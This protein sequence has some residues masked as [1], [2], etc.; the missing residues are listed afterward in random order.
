MKKIFGKI[1]LSAVIAVS[2][3]AA[4]SAEKSTNDYTIAG[5]VFQNDLFM[6][7]I[8]IGMQK[9]ADEKG[10]KLLLSNSDNKVDK[11]SQLIDTYISRKV[12]AIAITPLSEKGSVAALQRAK[13][14]GIKIIIFNT[15]LEADIYESY[16][17][18]DQKELGQRSGEAARAYIEKNYPGQDVDV[19]TLS[20]RSF[21]PE[22]AEARTGGFTGEIKD[23]PNVKFVSEQDAWLAEKAIVI[24]GDII[25][26]N[27]NI[28]VLHAAN[29]GGTIGAVQAVKNAGKAGEIVVFGTDG[30]DQIAQML[31]FKDNILQVSTAQQPYEIGFKAIDV[32]VDA[33]NGDAVEKTIIVPARV[34]DRENPDDV[35]AFRKELKSF[36]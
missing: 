16:I 33:L 24:A 8:Q 6:R 22:I 28:K 32:A 25:T 20:F 26:A 27:P 2:S 9:A 14:A 19:A 34:L 7:T 10:I 15:P 5:I 13:D 4:V 21:L 23:M 30:S 17:N 18:S 1:A 36:R 31:T 29:E 35:Q 12:D 11:E 3:F